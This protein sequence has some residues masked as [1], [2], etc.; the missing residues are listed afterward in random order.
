MNLTTKIIYYLSQKVI[1]SYISSKVTL[2][3]ICMRAYNESCD[4]KKSDTVFFNLFG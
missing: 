2:K 4:L 3:V 1:N